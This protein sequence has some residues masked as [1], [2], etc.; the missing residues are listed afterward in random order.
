MIMLIWEMTCNT[1]N[2]PLV[3]SQLCSLFFVIT[4]LSLSFCP[5]LLTFLFYSSLISPLC[6]TSVLLVYPFLSPAICLSNMAV[7]SQLGA[8]PSNKTSNT[9]PPQHNDPHFCFCHSC[10]MQSGAEHKKMKQRENHPANPAKRIYKIKACLPNNCPR[11]ATINSEFTFSTV[12]VILVCTLYKV[13][14]GKRMDIVTQC[15]DR[16]V[17]SLRSNAGT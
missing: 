10:Y 1:G 17:P 16:A 13:D 3:Y 4:F 9:V 2:F 11:M 7:P 15:W 14:E 8:F 6:F 5:S 12:M